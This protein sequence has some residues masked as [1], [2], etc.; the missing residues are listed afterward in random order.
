MVDWWYRVVG[1]G[2]DEE[3]VVIIMCMV[4]LIAVVVVIRAY[5]FAKLGEGTDVYD[6]RIVSR[7]LL[8]CVDSEYGRGTRGV[9]AEAVDCFCRKCDGRVSR[10]DFCCC[11]K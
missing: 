6:Q 5:E 4:C 8:C 3:G 1:G 2:R 9:C 7:P 10:P 11:F